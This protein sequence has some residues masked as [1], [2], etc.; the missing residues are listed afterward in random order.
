MQPN[1]D[2]SYNPTNLPSSILL[3]RLPE[4]VESFILLNRKQKGILG[5]QLFGCQTCRVIQVDFAVL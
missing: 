4:I 3:I 5:A 1:N 2:V